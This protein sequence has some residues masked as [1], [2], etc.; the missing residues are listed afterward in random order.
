[1]N[2]LL[3]LQDEIALKSK[4][5]KPVKKS[6]P[7]V[8][9]SWYGYSFE[10]KPRGIRNNNPGNIVLA[11]NDWVG[12]VPK[13][14]NTDGKFEQFTDYKYGVRAL[15]ILLR[16]YIN[17]G[18]NTITKVFEAY[19]PP[20]ENNTQ[21][22]IKFVANRLGI[23]ATDTITANK[24]TIKALS[25]AIAKME[26]GEEAITDAQFEEGFAE[27]SKEMKDELDPPVKAKSFWADESS[28]IF[29][30]DSTNWAY[31]H[32]KT[33]VKTITV[34]EKEP[35]SPPD[36]GF[37][38]QKAGKNPGCL[39]V[40]SVKNMVDQILGA[41]SAGEKIQKLNIYG[42]GAAGV[43]SAGDGQGWEAGK[44]INN[45]TAWQTEL[46]RLKG[47]FADGAEVFL[48]GC[49]TGADQAGANKLKEVADVLGVPVSGP[50][51]FIYGDCTEETGS[52]HQ[53]AYPGKPAPA[54]I[55]SP[56]DDRKKKKEASTAHSL[57]MAELKNN[58]TA[59]YFQPAK[60]PINMASDAKYKFTDAAT[61]KKFVDGID[62]SHTVNVKGYSGKLSGQLFF[63]KNGVP[64][65]YTVF[66]DCDFFL[67]KGDWTK[68]YE[69]KYS[70]KT[71]LKGLL[72]DRNNLFV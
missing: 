49:H 71:L 62:Y 41:L 50:T 56:S 61:V 64:E 14:K 5:K 4:K 45:D 25:Q 13:D 20:N 51:G 22:Y 8:A 3:E 12:K 26:N 44:H 42:H 10:K 39:R 9:K 54:P 17:G 2:R 30:D 28:Y 48:G 38:A 18:R 70:L 47:K 53:K 19:A 35:A 31:E 24:A 40:T 52:V 27:L 33:A 58:I 29:S 6:E 72:E 68:A 7:S 11:N 15:I 23:G 16:N 46:G 66:A 59:V 21:N 57:S 1:M 55:S 37:L 43:I 63:I 34:V 60:N 32:S 69:I 67:K 36:N 65:E